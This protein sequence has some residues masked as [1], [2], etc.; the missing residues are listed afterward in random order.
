MEGLVEDNEDSDHNPDLTDERVHQS[1]GT[2]ITERDY[3]SD[4]SE[5]P[6][7]F[8]GGSGLVEQPLE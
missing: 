6:D 1:G 4:L 3:R 8:T 5:S 7:N 2:T